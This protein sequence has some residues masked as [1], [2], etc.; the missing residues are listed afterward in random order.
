MRIHWRYRERERHNRADGFGRLSSVE[1]VEEYIAT[2]HVIH[3]NENVSP[4][5]GILNTSLSKYI[6]MKE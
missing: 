2:V 6:T 5:N 3:D 1:D 4:L